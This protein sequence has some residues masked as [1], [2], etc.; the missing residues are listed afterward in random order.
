MSGKILTH[1]RKTHMENFILFDGIPRSLDQ[2]E[3]FDMIIDDYIVFFLELD[4][5]TAIS[6][7]SGR[8]IDPKTG[9]S[10]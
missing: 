5:E 7:L 2:K 10:F 1:Y 3:M 9:E 4:K 6:R 8:R